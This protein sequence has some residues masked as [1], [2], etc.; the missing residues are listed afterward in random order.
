MRRDSTTFYMKNNR[1]CLRVQSGRKTRSGLSPKRSK[2]GGSVFLLRAAQAKDG[3]ST[4]P[5]SVFGG[6]P[7]YFVTKIGAQRKPAP[8]A[9]LPINHGV[10]IYLKESRGGA[11]ELLNV[12]VLKWTRTETTT[13]L[14]TVCSAR[15]RIVDSPH[16]FLGTSFPYLG[17][18]IS[19]S[20]QST[21]P[22]PAWILWLTSTAHSSED[23]TNF[24]VYDYDHE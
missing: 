4:S 6:R 8:D 16:P 24:N 14:R 11:A 7:A 17:R 15:T 3:A 23:S 18:P 21:T 12:L 2:S 20:I 19:L 22:C 10:D 13:A 9:P 1:T 5:V